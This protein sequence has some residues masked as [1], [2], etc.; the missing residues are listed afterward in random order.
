MHQRILQAIAKA[1][2]TEPAMLLDEPA[3]AK[4]TPTPVPLEEQHPSDVAD[5]FDNEMKQEASATPKPD[6]DEEP[7]AP[8]PG[9]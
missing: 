2:S 3:V 1:T 8:R 7:S 4:P 9:R 6:E 5:A